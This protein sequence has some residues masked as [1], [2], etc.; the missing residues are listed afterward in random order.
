M[1]R[2]KPATRALLAAVTAGLGA[3]VIAAVTHPV[4]AAGD[5]WLVFCGVIIGAG[6]MLR[7]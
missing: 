1:L 5:G 7:K 4:S 3:G 6:M 2:G